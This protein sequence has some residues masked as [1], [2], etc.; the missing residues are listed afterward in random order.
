[1][2]NPFTSSDDYCD[3]KSIE[4][5]ENNSSSVYQSTCPYPADASDE[6]K[7]LTLNTSQLLDT[8]I[9]FKVTIDGGATF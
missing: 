9:N 1:M 5:V 3:I 2:L 6:C 4:M 7:K 8:E